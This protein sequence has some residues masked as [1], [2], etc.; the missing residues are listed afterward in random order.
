MEEII[1]FNEG[2]KEICL[3]EREQL[4]ITGNLKNHLYTLDNTYVA[5]TRGSK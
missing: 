1:N 4:K 5:T 2:Q 3:P